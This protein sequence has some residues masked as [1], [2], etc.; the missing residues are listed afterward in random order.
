MIAPLFVMAIRL[1]MLRKKKH[2]TLGQYHYGANFATRILV[3]PSAHL[4]CTCYYRLPKHS[5]LKSG[6]DFIVS[7]KEK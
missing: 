3:E 2:E 4:H 6:T 5:I 1:R 7:V